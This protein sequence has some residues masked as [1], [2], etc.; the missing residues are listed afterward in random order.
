MKDVS[1]LIVMRLKA[2]G[3]RGAYIIDRSHQHQPALY[4]LAVGVFCRYYAVAAMV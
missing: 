2:C 1:G 4:P 3:E